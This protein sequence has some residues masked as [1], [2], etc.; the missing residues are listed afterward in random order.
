[1]ENTESKNKILKITIRE[2]YYRMGKFKINKG[3][4]Y[5]KIKDLR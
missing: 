5:L 4:I 3:D 2:K 1:M